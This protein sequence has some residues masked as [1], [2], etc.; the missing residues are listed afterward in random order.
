MLAGFMNLFN[1]NDE[2]RISRF[3]GLGDFTLSIVVSIFLGVLVLK[4]SRK[5]K[6]GWKYQVYTLV[7]IMIFSSILILGDQAW[8]VV[9]LSF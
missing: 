1:L 2:G 3:L 4:V 5:Y 6:P 9:L 8:G 7:L